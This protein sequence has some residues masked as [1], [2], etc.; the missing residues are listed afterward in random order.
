MKQHNTIPVGMLPLAFIC[1]LGS[2]ARLGG[3]RGA[4]HLFLDSRCR[5]AFAVRNG[6]GECQTRCISEGADAMTRLSLCGVLFLGGLM[7]VTVSSGG[8]TSS[9]ESAKRD[10]LTVCSFVRF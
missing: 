1:L 9:S 6:V 3:R 5:S 10:T 2:A 8:C 7:L 4:R